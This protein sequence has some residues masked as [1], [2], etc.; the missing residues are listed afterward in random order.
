MVILAL[1][2]FAQVVAAPVAEFSWASH[3][4]EAGDHVIFQGE[5]LPAELS[6]DGTP[7][8]SQQ[9]SARSAK[10]QLPPS[11]A[12]G[13]RIYRVS[14][15]AASIAVNAPEVAFFHRFDL[16]AGGE[17]LA[18]GRSLAFDN[19]TG[20]CLSDGPDKTRRSPLYD[21]D[22]VPPSGCGGVGNPGGCAGLDAR[23]VSVTA[24]T[25][26]IALHVADASCYRLRLVLPSNAAPGGY[27]LQL[28]N[29]LVDSSGRLRFSAP[30]AE[31]D[32]EAPGPAVFTV[33]A[34]PPSAKW[35]REVFIADPDYEYRFT[36]A[37]GPCS[38]TGCLIIRRGNLSEALAAAAS[39][40]GGVVKLL[41]GSFRMNA[42]SLGD[43]LGYK[44]PPRTKLVGDKGRSAIVF[45]GMLNKSQIPHE[46]FLYG[47]DF[48][49]HNLTI[50][51]GPGKYGAVFSVLATSSSAL[52]DGL[53]VRANPYA[54]IGSPGGPRWPNNT[55]HEGG[56]SYDTDVSVGGAIKILGNYTTIRNSDVYLAGHWFIIVG[57]GG[58]NAKGTVV[59]RNRLSYAS[60]LFYFCGSSRSIISN[61]LIFGI[62][63]ASQNSAFATY[64]EGRTD[65]LAATNNAFANPSSGAS[66]GSL[67]EDG[68]GG[69]Y[70]DTLEHVSADG[71]TLTLRSTPRIG[72]QHFIGAAVY[73]LAG[74][75][76]GQ[77]RRVVSFSGTREAPGRQWTISSKFDISLDTSGGRDASFVAIGPYRGKFFWTGNVGVDNQ[78][79]WLWGSSINVILADNVLSRSQ[80]FVLWPQDEKISPTLGDGAQPNF[81][82]QILSNT[83]ESGLTYNHGR[84]ECAVP[85]SPPAIYGKLPPCGASEQDE[86]G[87]REYLQPGVSSQPGVEIQSC[88]YNSTRAESEFKNIPLTRGVVMRG[89]RFLADANIVFGAESVAD[90]IVEGNSFASTEVAVC[91]SLR[92]GDQGVH[93]VLLSEN[94]LNG[95][96][97][98]QV[99]EPIISKTVCQ[100]HRWND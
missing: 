91:V 8:A 53:F 89:N 7:V 4:A 97:V 64:G 81:R 41:P 63:I 11:K 21:W 85:G 6:V 98:L 57:E 23:L 29:G 92:N 26:M 15:G 47:A 67:T 55:D 27:H 33:A 49:L 12:T 22:V 56:F 14:A 90:V 77:F 39:N 78:G 34:V 65:M 9:L 46:A 88:V 73:V 69:A 42:T 2:L 75:G 54:G 25:T 50:Y 10:V 19:Y 40:G 17:L 93:S 76:A 86:D 87:P 13:N 16:V 84:W 20:Q 74:R 59:D 48:E 44:I 94:E 70:N 99:S 28:K 37:S 95:G 60:G 82:V 30:I 5:H 32:G 45:P 38:P 83:I 1:L 68:A 3:P 51:A 52:F 61:N 66:A 24:P 35:P 18:F 100:D 71:R 79:M 36:N 62:A 96:L 72:N 31:S 43:P 80:A 58:I